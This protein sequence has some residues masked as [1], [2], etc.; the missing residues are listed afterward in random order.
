MHATMI[1]IC[2]V[3]VLALSCVASVQAAPRTVT[4]LDDGWQFAKGAP[5][6][7]TTVALPHTFNAD[8]GTSPNFYRGAGWYRRTITVGRSNA[9]RTYLEFDGA[10]LSTDVWLNGTRIGRHEGGFARFRFDVT[11]H[12]RPG[13]NALLVR[14]DNTRQPDV[15]PLGGD[16]TLYGG[17]YRHVRLV[18]TD[19]VHIDMLDAG[20]PGVYFSTPQA[21]RPHWR[22]RVANDRARPEN[23]VV[24]ARL[25]DAG[26]KVV[27]TAQRSVALPA[28]AVVPVELDAV[29]ANPH[30]WQGVEDPYLYTSEVTVARAGAVLDRVDNEVGI[31]TVQLDPD[32]GLLLNGRP[33]RVHGVNVHLTYVPGKGVAVDDADIDDDYRILSELGVTGLR[34]A[35]YQHNEHSYALSD[36]KGFL[37]WTELPLTSE[38]NGSDAYAANAA[39]QAR[40]LVRQNFNHPSVFV[41]GLGNEIYKVDEVSGRVLDAMQKLVHA[42]DASRPTAYANCCAPIDGPQAMHT[43][44]VG[45]N[46]Y[47]GWYDKEFADLAPFL[48]ANHAKRPRTPKSLSEYGAG[49][50]ALH[51]EDPVRR[52][53]APSRWHPEQYQ[54]LYHEAAWRQIEAAPWL[55]ASYVWTG[56]DFASAGR[57]EGDARG[58]NDKGLVSMDRK[59]RK[60][61]YYWYQANW[62]KQPMVYITSRRAVKR[63]A[64]QVE[65]KVYSNQPAA[66]LR[67]N[68]TDQG[69]RAVEGH[70][71]RWPVRLAPGT[72]RIE[73]QAG[74]VQDSVEWHLEP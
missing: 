27:A 36:R 32:R 22:A 69:E 20:G 10:A 70:I 39:Q 45:S 7:W 41:W 59:V 5:S 16:Y 29:L 15:A 60:D 4:A 68:G 52:P 30:L 72:N 64:A 42:E 2:R 3:L 37:V 28:R 31:R 61:A 58:V 18:A 57:N 34:F 44:A 12:L 49:G 48:A 14:V 63:T 65:V 26:G 54:A 25:R 21:D 50:S 71:A 23:V 19:D 1:R 43:D 38:V 67:V 9:G 73:V 35:H 24:T 17:L 51:Q 53:V 66:W 8:D 74:A 11:D 56:F 33:Y 46:V 40:E 55:W 6:G 13:A 62:S 47:F